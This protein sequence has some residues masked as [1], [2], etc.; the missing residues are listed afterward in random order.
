MFDLKPYFD[1]AQKAEEAVNH[2]MDEM[3]GHYTSGTDEGKQAALDLRPA[4]DEAKAKA[5]EA[6]DLY[7]SMRDAAAQSN[8]VAREFVPVPE[9]KAST[10]GA[11]EITLSDFNDL[12]DTA[13][14]KF[15]RSGGTIKPESD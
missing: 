13:K 4:L 5:K 7:T 10:E 12:D 2:L 9:S 6:N 15:M 3:N 11:K 1:A 8:S 14:V